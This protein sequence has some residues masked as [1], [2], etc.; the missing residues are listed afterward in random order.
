V[1]AVGRA[2]WREPRSRWLALLFGWLIVAGLSAIPYV[3]G[4]LWFAGAV[5]GL[6][7]STVAAWRARRLGGRHRPGGKMQPEPVVV[8][9]EEGAPEPMI[10]ERAMGEEGTGL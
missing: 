1:Y 3:G 10:V 4:F 5:L 7:A 8:L 6:G 9:A 2:L